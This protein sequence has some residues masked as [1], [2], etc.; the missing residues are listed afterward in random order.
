MNSRIVASAYTPDHQDV[1]G[2]SET[3]SLDRWV[4]DR[5]IDF[6]H[7]HRLELQHKRRM[8]FFLHLLGLDMAG[9]IHKPNSE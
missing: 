8:V 2:K 6:L 3:S 1:S 5:A 4:F 9:H 7:R